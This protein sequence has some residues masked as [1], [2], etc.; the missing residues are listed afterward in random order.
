[1]KM[2]EMVAALLSVILTF[3]AGA[4]AQAQTPSAAQEAGA[5]FQSR[6]WD[7]ASKAYEA[8]TKAE[9]QNGQAWLRLGMSL[10]ALN[11]HG[12]A[13][14][15]LQ[16]AVEVLRGPVAMYTLGSAYAGMKDKERAFEWLNKASAAGFSQ[17]ARLESDPNLSG[18]RDD[19]RFKAV[20]EG[21]E[22]NARPCK[23]APEARQFDFWVG[24]WDVQT[25]GLS[26]GTNVVERLEEGCLIMENWT[27]RGGSTGKSM[28]FYDPVVKKWRQTYIGN[29]RAV[30][31]MSGEYRDGAM[32][33]EGEIHTPNGNKTLTRVTLYGLSP[34]RIRHTQDDSTD[35]GKTWT[36]VWD[37]VYVRKKN[38]GQ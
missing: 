5:L 12:E 19:A 24:E 37:S 9:P 36:N 6:K 14:P 31:E 26:V 22:R 21:T 16:K 17:L 33:Y 28:N 30:W 1:M 23:Y 4:A 25:G 13:L 10:M 34:D 3:S 29:S 32:R 18:L 35:G 11:K 20:F 27:G 2:K 8:L 7:E 38:A 15:P